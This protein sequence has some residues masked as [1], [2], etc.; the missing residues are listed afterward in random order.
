MLWE[1]FSLFDLVPLTIILA[2]MLMLVFTFGVYIFNFLLFSLI[3]LVISTTIFRKR[4]G[5]FLWCYS[6]PFLLIGIA[7][8]KMATS[9]SIGGAIVSAIFLIFLAVVPALVSSVAVLV[10]TPIAK[11]FRKLP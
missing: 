2:T 4:M 10:S 9:G 8:R 6:I 1:I 11:K 7:V 5:L 3:F